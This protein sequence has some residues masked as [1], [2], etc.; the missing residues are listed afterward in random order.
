[1]LVPGW[2]ALIGHPLAEIVTEQWVR[3]MRIL[4]AD[5]ER[6]SPRS[7]CVTNHDALVANPCPELA[8]VLGF[9]SLDARYAPAAAQALVGEPA[10]AAAAET[11]AARRELAPYLPRTERLAAWAGDWIATAPD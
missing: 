10:L 11:S 8:R 2:Q 1:L 6:L 3:T 9:L 7:W 4:V 5:L